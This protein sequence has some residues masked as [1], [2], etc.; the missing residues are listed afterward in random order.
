MPAR[1]AH[2]EIQGPNDDQTVAFYRE[3]LGWP[4]DPRGPGYTLIDAS[5]AG[6]G[7][8]IADAAEP[9][10]VLGVAV[11]DLDAT[12]ARV[13]ELGGEV[14]MPPTDNGWVTKALVTDPG[15]NQLS[16]IADKPS[17]GR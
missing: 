2:F 5:A 1:I 10:V 17:V 8:A 16:L 14:L 11:S 13:A 12:I 6:L 9:R 4:T 3:L 7:G 15:G